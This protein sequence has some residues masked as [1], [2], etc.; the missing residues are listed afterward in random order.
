MSNERFPITT[1]TQKTDTKKRERQATNVRVC[2]NRLR[3]V[4]YSTKAVPTHLFSG[5]SLANH[6]CVLVDPHFGRG[7]HVSGAG[8]AQND[9]SFRGEPTRVHSVATL[10]IG[11]DLADG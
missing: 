10:V 11:W 5:E 4:V 8:T 7:R 1:A 9:G 6:S 2:E 3:P